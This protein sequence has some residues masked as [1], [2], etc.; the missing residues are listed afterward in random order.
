MPTRFQQ[1]I[2]EFSDYAIFD[3]FIQSKSRRF[4]VSLSPFFLVKLIL[5][6]FLRLVSAI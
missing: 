4:I 1:E 2:S 6:S 3:S 5:V